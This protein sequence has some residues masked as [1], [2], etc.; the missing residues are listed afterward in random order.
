MIKESVSE[1]N[2]NDAWADLPA[3]PIMFDSTKSKTCSACKEVAYGITQEQTGK[4]LVICIRGGEWKGEDTFRDTGS[5]Y[6]YAYICGKCGHID[7]YSY[8]IPKAE[9]QP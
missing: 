8:L 7:L 3:M 5:L 4:E 9:I 6:S 2:I 1:F